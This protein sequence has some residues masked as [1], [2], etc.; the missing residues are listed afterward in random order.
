MADKKKSNKSSKTTPNPAL[1]I[2]LA[3]TAVS[4]WI[5]HPKFSLSEVAASNGIT[6][7]ELLLQFK[8]REELLSYYYESRWVLFQTLKDQVPNYNEYTVEEKLSNLFY[9][10]IDLMSPQKDF[11]RKTAHSPL[12]CGFHKAFQKEIRTIFSGKE[13][14]NT[15]KIAMATPVAEFLWISFM[16]V[17]R[18]WISDTSS[19]GENTAAL[20]DKGVAVVAELATNPL[21][22]K[23][24][25]LGRFLLREFPL[26]REWSTK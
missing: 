7:R 20:I 22:D 14:S 8:S 9:S 11:V 23:V 16:G 18:Y 3:E 26:S 21:G 19:E 2:D 15:I 12:F 10:L 1:R 25:D 4:K 17:L 13:V 5:I 24:I 6:L